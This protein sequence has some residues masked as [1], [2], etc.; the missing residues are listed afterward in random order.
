EHPL[1]ESLR[2]QLVRA[3]ESSGRRAE[4]LEAARAARRALAEDLG[5]EPSPQLR[6]LLDGVERE[7]GAPARRQVVCVA[8]DVRCVADDDELLDP[9]VLDDV[10]RRGA[11]EAATVLRRHGEPVIE[12]LPDGLVAVFGTRAS[13]EDDGLRAVRAARALERR[14]AELQREHEGVPV[15][16]GLGVSAGT[17]LV[18]APD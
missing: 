15:E 6:A 12:R 8:V 16:V 3:L 10:M 2:L 9:E 4:A 17:A 14:L 5:L 13:H 11:D 7:Q 18:T 1:R